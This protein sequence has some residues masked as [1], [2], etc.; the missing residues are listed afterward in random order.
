MKTF[1]V[2]TACLALLA[3]CSALRQWN[4]L[5]NYS[6]AA[7][8][9]EHGKNYDESEY[10]MRKALFESRLAAALKHNADET[11][12]WKQGIN[13]FSDRT[14]EEQ[15]RLLGYDQELGYASRA[16]KSHKRFQNLPKPEVL[17]TLPAT[18]DWREK[19]VITAVKDQGDCGSCWT[20]GTAETVESH[21]AIATGSLMDLSE[22]QI[23]DCTPNPDQCGGTGGCGGGTAELAMARIIAMGGLSAEW[24]YPYTSYFGSDFQCHFNATRT[25]PV[26]KLSSYVDLPTNQYDPI[27]T[28]VASAGPL[29]I[30]VDASSWF[31]YAGGVF[32]GCNQ[33]NPDIDHAVQLVGY[34]TDP[35]WGDYWLVRNSW[36]SLWGEKGYI[37]LRRTSSE[38]TRCGT[39]LTPSDGDGCAN[40]PKTVTVCGTCGIL[41]DVSYPIIQK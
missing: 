35:K 26:A 4:E 8:I 37:R 13:H 30:S 33:T 23:L 20:F 17:S 19:G 39:D 25:A 1:F 32:D 5:E 6:F 41:F 3:C 36:S 14:E 2:I 7:Y 34:G 16:S 22:Q 31:S 27:M 21:F 38:Q 9:K 24:T 18:V 12:S 10:A 40:G 15:R 11:K 28:A 29:V